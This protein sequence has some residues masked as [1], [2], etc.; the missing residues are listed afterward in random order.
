MPFIVTKIK[1][2]LAPLYNYPIR[3]K[4][5]SIKKIESKSGLFKFDKTVRKGQKSKVVHKGHIGGK[6]PLFLDKVVI[7]FP[8]NEPSH[9][10]AVHTYM[11]ELLKDASNLDKHIY[12]DKDSYLAKHYAFN[13]KYETPTE[14]TIYVSFKPRDPTKN[15]LRIQFNVKKLVDAGEFEY[16]SGIINGLFAYHDIDWNGVRV[17]R[18]EAA[19]DVPFARELVH[20]K[21]KGFSVNNTH[22]GVN[23]FMQTEYVGAENSKL[24]FCVYD[25]NLE[26][27][28]KLGDAYVPTEKKLTR[29]ETRLKKMKIEELKEA[30]PFKTAQVY[31]LPEH[32]EVSNFVIQWFLD[33]IQ[34]RGITAV[35]AMIPTKYERDKYKGILEAYRAEFWD[36]DQLQAQYLKELD[37]L[38]TALDTK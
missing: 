9:K 29:V 33:S 1:S 35:L 19:L 27:Q 7:T 26:R 18:L 38:I 14:N 8:C 6:V 3:G 11:G 28:K 30:T 36:P 23:N 24:T 16:L 12:L 2:A 25:K 17:N 4:G 15:Y 5:L 32:P 34:I 13:Y 21:A 22:N 20:L 37:N 10:G 31:V